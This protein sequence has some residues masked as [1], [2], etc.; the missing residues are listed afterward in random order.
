MIK[1]HITNTISNYFHK[2][3]TTQF[4]NLI[5]NLINGCYVKC[6]GLDMDEFK[7][8]QVIKL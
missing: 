8:I 3:A 6:L 1:K 5:Q 4:P 7:I 2:F